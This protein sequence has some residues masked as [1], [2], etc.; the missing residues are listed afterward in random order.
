TCPNCGI[1]HVRDHN[2]AK[3]ILAKGLAT[4]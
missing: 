4:L 3:N 1:F 2:A